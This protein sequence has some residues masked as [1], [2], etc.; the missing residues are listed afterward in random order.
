MK[1]ILLKLLMVISFDRVISLLLSIFEKI[2]IKRY[3]KL[4]GCKINFVSQGF[5]G[6]DL[7][8][9]LCKF[10]IDETSHLKSNTFIE[11]SGG[12]TICQL[13]H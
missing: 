6:V 5:G 11:C 8:G 10:K 2:K 3:E 4:C 13:K 12:E 7:A 1:N 9:D